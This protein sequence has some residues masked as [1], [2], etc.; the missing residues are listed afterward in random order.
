MTNVS[1]SQTAV[2]AHFIHHAVLPE[3]FQTDMRPHTLCHH[4]RPLLSCSTLP[5]F[6]IASAPACHP[7]SYGPLS[8]PQA[9]QRGTLITCCPLRALQAVGPK[10]MR[11]QALLKQEHINA[12]VCGWR[13]GQKRCAAGKDQGD[14]LGEQG[15]MQ[16][17]KTL[18]EHT[19]IMLIDI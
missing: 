9:L 19:V 15:I 8:R 14:Y 18:K 3:T 17:Q 16:M 1:C 12:S 13:A 11:C 4:S 5:P 10:L 7:A 2:I 6:T